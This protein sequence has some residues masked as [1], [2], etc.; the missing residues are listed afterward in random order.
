MSARSLPVSGPAPHNHP[1]QY[2]RLVGRANELAGLQ[3]QIL[4]EEA[5]LITLTGPGGIGKTR[6][7]VEAGLL[8]RSAFPDGVFLVA[9]SPLRDPDLVLPA[10]AQ[11][12]GLRETGDP[13]L[14]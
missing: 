4:R 2:H 1:R 9:L 8:L 14:V 6:L 11:T 12:L 3:T 5:G 13:T 7:A 10:I